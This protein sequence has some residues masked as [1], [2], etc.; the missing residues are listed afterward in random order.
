LARVQVVL[1]RPGTAAN[2]GAVARAIRN[3]GLDGLALVAAADWRSVECWRSAWGAHEVLEQARSFGSLAEALAGSALAVGFSGKAGAGPGR[4]VREVAAELAGLETGAMASLVFGP[5]SAGLNHAEL[6]L[7]G[8]RAVIPSH[9][10][11]PSLNLSHAVMVAGY[12]V[13]RARSAPSAP[14]ERR[15]T[16]DEKQRMLCLLRDGLRAIEAL[17][18]ANTE[19]YFEE[20]R[21][22][23]QRTDLTPRELKLLEHMARK[24]TACRRS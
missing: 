23:F 21:A 3:T 24:M 10:A 7:C 9:P 19:G 22:L 5:E 20:W 6:A 8:V 4:D 12:E 11:Q 16:H 13:F 14:G 2:V 18:R 17:P 15:A 1:V